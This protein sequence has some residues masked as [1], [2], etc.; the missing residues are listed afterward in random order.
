V[1]LRT[2]AEM[3][4]TGHPGARP[5]VMVNGGRAGDVEGDWSASL[6]WLVGRLAP[7]RPD[8]AFHEVRYR[9][10]SWNRLRMCIEDCLA[11]IDAVA[12]AGPVTLVGF[13]M[14]GAVS[15]ASA[16]HLAVRDVIGLAPWIPAQLD[17]DG[18]RGRRVTIVHGSLDAALPG[19]PGVRSSSSRRGAD[20]IERAGVPV[21]YHLITG[22][23]HP[24]ALHAPWGRPVGAPRA[25]TWLGHV[26]DALPAAEVP[27]G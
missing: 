10:K 3:R 14:G 7:A 9:V 6:E 1:R 2:G 21:D 23:V 17:V 20:R 15:I 5:V 22:A 16:G 18:L 4:T 13:S 24:I 12:D 19:V 27:P 26:A 25:R 8:L 11:A